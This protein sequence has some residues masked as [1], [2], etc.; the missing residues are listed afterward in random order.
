MYRGAILDSI[1]SKGHADGRW[2]CGYILVCQEYETA[3]IYVLNDRRKTQMYTEWVSNF[4]KV[5]ANNETIYTTAYGVETKKREHVLKTTYTQ[6]SRSNN[7][8]DRQR[9]YNNLARDWRAPI[10]WAL[11]PYQ[12]RRCA[13][14]PLTL[15]ERRLR[16]VGGNCTAFSA[17]G[18]PGWSNR[19]SSNKFAR[20]WAEMIWEC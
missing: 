6:S 9:P 15:V 5:S 14:P 19:G 12:R 1:Q 20:R 7:N 3:W 4:D 13:L 16:L 8:N 11:P 18:V 17:L 10:S 2:C